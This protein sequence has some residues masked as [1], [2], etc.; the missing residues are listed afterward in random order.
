[1]KTNAERQAEYRKRRKTAGESGERQIKHWVSNAAFT[2]LEELAKHHGI[3][4]KEL[5]ERLI[6]DAEKAIKAPPANPPKKSKT[7][8]AESAKPAK[9]APGPKM[10]EPESISSMAIHQFQK[11]KEDLPKG[12]AALQKA[13]DSARNRT[14]EIIKGLKKTE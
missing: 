14:K 4:K 1:M 7:P 13:V 5:L 6:L 12:M 8:A 9:P 2:A 11:I 10:A 3:S